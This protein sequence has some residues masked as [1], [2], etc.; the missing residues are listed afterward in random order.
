MRV[1]ARADG[2]EGFLSR[3]H[4]DGGRSMLLMLLTSDW[5]SSIDIRVD[6][7]DK[8]HRGRL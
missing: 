1:I 3:H 6:A 2:I 4:E 8:R 7:G 5:I